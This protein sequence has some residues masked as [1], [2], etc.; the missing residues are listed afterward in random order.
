MAPTRHIS[1]SVPFTVT[2][3]AVGSGSLVVSSIPSTLTPN[4][5]ASPMTEATPF[6]VGGAAEFACARADRGV[7]TRAANAASQAAKRLAAWARVES[8]GMRVCCRALGPRKLPA[9]GPSNQ[10]RP[11]GTARGGQSVGRINLVEIAESIFA[12][13]DCSR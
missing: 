10:R 3:N 13:V 7:A 5:R 12:P 9:S 11:A 1:A 4:V 8:R 2:V 6:D